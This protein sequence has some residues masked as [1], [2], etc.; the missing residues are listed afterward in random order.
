M[1]SL[2]LPT[3]QWAGKRVLITGHTGFKGSW[4]SYYLYLAGAKLFGFSLPVD[5]SNYLYKSLRADDFFADCMYASINEPNLLGQFVAKVSPDYIF[6][7]AAQPLVAESY[8]SPVYTWETNVMGTFN[9]LES[10]K[11]LNSKCVCII[12]TTDKVY[13]NCEQISGYDE[14]DMLGGYDPLGL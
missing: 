13:K 12:I 7:L 9:L 2:K 8:L 3:S 14:S 11:A 10:L 4:L 5:D 6:H 1:T